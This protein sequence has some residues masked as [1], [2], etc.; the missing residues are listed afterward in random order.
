MRDALAD[1]ERRYSEV[2]LGAARILATDLPLISIQA[3]N[4]SAKLPEIEE[5]AATVIRRK[6]NAEIRRAIRQVE[7]TQAYLCLSHDT[8]M[9]K[10]RRR[11]FQKDVER[12]HQGLTRAFRKN[13]LVVPRHWPMHWS[14]GVY[15]PINTPHEWLPKRNKKKSEW[16]RLAPGQ[17]PEILTAKKQD[18][19]AHKMVD[20]LVRRQARKGKYLNDARFA[21]IYPAQFRG[22]SV[23]MKIEGRKS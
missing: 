23:I 12:C 11:I 10:T 22:N 4:V 2:R 16:A 20:A 17:N 15:A 3:C 7:K 14:S 18:D 5:R 1:A 19:R 21:G 8:R 13:R 6:C 9:Q